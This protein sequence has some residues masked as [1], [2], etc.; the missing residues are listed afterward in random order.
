MPPHMRR[1]DMTYLL[2][3]HAYLILIGACNLMLCPI[4]H[5]RYMEFRCVNVHP[6][7]PSSLP[8]KLN[9]LI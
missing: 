4:H 7:H 9:L 1:C 2:S 8:S 6:R 5:A 3:A